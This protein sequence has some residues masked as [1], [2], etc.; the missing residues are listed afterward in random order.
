MSEQILEEA[1]S[2]K[3]TY[4]EYKNMESMWA[5]KEEAFWR[6]RYY[7]YLK[8]NNLTNLD[9]SKYLYPTSY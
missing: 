1:G 7:S 2:L 6:D 5:M 9:V 8:E 3:K 4:E